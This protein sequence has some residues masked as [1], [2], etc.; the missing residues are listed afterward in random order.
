MMPSCPY[1]VL[2]T[3]SSPNMWTCLW[4]LVFAW[5]QARSK[6][7]GVDTSILHH[8]FMLIFIAS[9]A[10]ISLHG[11]I[12]MPFLSYFARFTWRGRM[13][14]AGILAWKRSK[15]KMPILRN[16][17]SCENQRGFFLGFIKN[18][19]PKKCQRGTR[20]CP[21]TCTARPPPQ[22]APWGLVGSR[23]RALQWNQNEST[24]GTN[25]ILSFSKT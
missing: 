15:F 12:L 1:Y 24:S 21:Q 4:N 18:T 7:G 14:A 10:V 25:I 3:P 9:L 22:A 11:T 16:S 8:V 6:L 17:K 19:G 2:S 20:G 23:S 5:G 13:P